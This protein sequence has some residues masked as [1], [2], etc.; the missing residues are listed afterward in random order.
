MEGL[1]FNYGNFKSEL[2]GLLTTHVLESFCDALPHMSDVVREK[3]LE[4]R[5]TYALFSYL[6]N[7]GYMSE[8]SGISKLYALCSRASGLHTV[9]ELCRTFCPQMDSSPAMLNISPVKFRTVCAHLDGGGWEEVAHELG[10]SDSSRLILKKSRDPTEAIIRS[11]YAQTGKMITVNAFV[12]ILQKI[13]RI[14]VAILLAMEA[15][16]RCDVEVASP[17]TSSQMPPPPVAADSTNPLASAIAAKQRQVVTTQSFLQDSSNALR[18]GLLLAMDE[19]EAWF[20]LLAA[21]DLLHDRQMEAWV[22]SLRK[23][24]AATRANEPSLQV[25]R[26]LCQHDEDFARGTLVDLANLLN[27]LKIFTVTQA[28]SKA[29]EF[30]EGN[31]A[32]TQEKSS[33]AF[34]AQGE[35]R[36]WLTRN[37]ICDEHEV[38]VG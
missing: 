23:E 28:I 35:L 5:N 21:K 17:P 2:R 14:D 29:V 36:E 11:H 27:P 22:A 10:I 1:S 25:V 30:Y 3:I 37:D 19:S 9:S 15:T 31:R 18:N 20:A 13:G 7:C 32:K 38:D 16:I 34:S 12:R 26:S 4:Q 33:E 6:E 24:W 8:H